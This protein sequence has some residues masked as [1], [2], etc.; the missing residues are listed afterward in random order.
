LRHARQEKIQAK[1]L[2]NPNGSFPA[3]LLIGVKAETIT[4]P[5][6]A[7]METNLPVPGHLRLAALLGAVLLGQTL[8][9]KA[10]DACNLAFARRLQAEGDSSIIGSDFRKIISNQK[11]LKLTGLGADPWMIAAVEGDAVPVA[12]E[13]AVP[14]IATPPPSSTNALVSPIT[15]VPAAAGF[16]PANA[17][18]APMPEWMKTAEFSEIHQ[19][20]HA[21]P[22]PATSTVP[23]DTKPDKKVSIEL[24]EGEAYI[25]NGVM[26]DGFLT[27]GKVPGP[28]I[29][30]DEGDVVEFTVVNKGTIPHGAS[31]H[32]AYTQ[33]SKYLGKIPAGESR[34]VVFQVNTPGVYM[35]HCAP[36]GHA[37]PMHV[38]FGQYGMMVV[39]PKKEQYRLEKEM[40]RAPD[41]ELFLL[42]HELYASGH[43]AIEGQPAYTMFNGKLFRYVEEPIKVR[44]GDYVRIYFLNV[45]PNLLSTFHIVGIIWDYA[46]WQGNPAVCLPGGQSVT[47]GPTDSWVID[48]RVPPDEGAYTMLSHAVG[49]TSRGAIGL[50]V[51][52]KHAKTQPQ[53]LADGPSLTPAELAEAKTKA[54]RVISPFKPGTHPDDLPVIYGP[55]T[56]EVHVSIIGNSF[57]PKVIRVAPGTKIT[58][59]NEDAFTYLAGEFAGIHNAACMSSPDGAEG[60]ITPLLAHGESHT[61]EI[62]A[63]GGDYE[64]MCTPHPYM[65]GRVEVRKPEYTLASGDATANGGGGATGPWVLA[66]LGA[67]FLASLAALARRNRPATGEAATAS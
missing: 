3:I 59:T 10:C 43:S 50:I 62:G 57:H 5:H 26:Y 19:R 29:I 21:L 9:T 42:Q 13:S 17:P 8:S 63:Q 35:Y 2:K 33:T 40:G 23:Q 49:S 11:G 4:L 7:P 27:N 45:G 36:G 12:S 66:A 38:L 6:D 25:G 53:I 28:T 67:C 22:L 58:W 54:K 37:I 16:Q 20:D 60:F 64:Y 32:S 15:A 61:V 1:L 48:F 46:Y 47:A 56:K 34:K 65:K 24:G 55:E 30:V 44:P 41:C 31:I 52:E 51:A 18:K 14:S 39:K